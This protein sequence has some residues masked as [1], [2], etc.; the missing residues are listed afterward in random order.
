MPK[1]RSEIEVGR[2]TNGEKLCID[3]PKMKYAL[4]EHRVIT[5]IGVATSFDLD[6]WNAEYKEPTEKCTWIKYDYRTVCPKE[7]DAD[8]PY[9][10]IPENRM[11]TLKYCPY[12]GK[13]IEVQE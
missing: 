12:C 2:M 7:H 11:E 9:W 8:N 10:R 4:F 13:E 1:L 5:T 3:F 6:W